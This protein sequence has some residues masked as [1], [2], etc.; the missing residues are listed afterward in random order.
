MTALD[1]EAAHLLE[2]WFGEQQGGFTDAAH[3]QRWFM[4]G[5][6]FDAECRRA[7]A[8]CH[9]QAQA[10]KLEHWHQS[11][12]GSLAFIVLCDQIPRNIYRDS[13]LAFSTDSE[14][15]VTARQLVDAGS[16][17]NFGFDKRAFLYLPFEHSE[18][19]LDQH[20]SVGLFTALR[21]QTPQGERHLTGSYLQ[22]AH[23]HRDTIMRFGRFPHRNA[24]LGRTSTAAELEYLSR[25]DANA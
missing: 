24:A 18:S 10:G 13:A 22:H 4:G 2:F 25:S 20:T 15:L 7:F 3:R 14:A 1:S 21:D 6:E 5:S 8:A 17:Q 11:A 19:L 16:D 12:A 9:E 23:Q